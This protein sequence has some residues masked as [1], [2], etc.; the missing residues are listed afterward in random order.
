MP[1]FNTPKAVLQEAIASVKAQTH[2][3]WELCIADDASSAAD[4]GELLDEAAADP[5]VRVTRL[6]RNGGISAAT[7][8]AF[9]MSSGAWIAL[10]DHDDLLAPQALELMTA[11]A[12]MQPSAAL[13]YSDEDKLNGRGQRMEPYFKPR[14]SWELFRSQ[15]YLGHLILY[16]RDKIVAAGGWRSDYD[17]SQDYDLALRVLEKV[18]IAD[19]AHI[20]R[21]AL[22]LEGG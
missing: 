9:A 2:S 15:N 16:R 7:N 17:G 13:I 10:L 3:R 4:V 8:A 19:A 1:T 20:P 6:P 11:R 5:R 18:A 14:F 12:A 22:P 21:C